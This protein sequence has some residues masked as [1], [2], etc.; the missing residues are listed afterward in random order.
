ML[1]ESAA[2]EYGERLLGIVLTGGNEDGAAGLQAIRAAGGMT[3][4]QQPETA[5]VRYMPE[6]ALQRGEVDYVLTLEQIA[7]LL[8][9]LQGK[10]K[11]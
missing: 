11:K 3:V 10:I 8:G 9:T 5:Q 7:A 4:V 1:F 2:D 6:L